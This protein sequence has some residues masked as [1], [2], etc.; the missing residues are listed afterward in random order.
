[1]LPLAYRLS[2][3]ETAQAIGQSVTWTCRLRNRFL[4]GETVGDGQRQHAGGRRRQNL[5]VEQEREILT[6]FLARSSVYQL[7]HRH[8]W[9]KPAPDKR[10]L[11]RD[12]VASGVNSPRRPNINSLSASSHLSKTDRVSNLLW[13]RIGL[14]MA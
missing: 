7:L 1:M 9:R 8:G 4:V 14:L 2:L 10:H 12:P 6:P 11:Q 3:D 13:L 5:S